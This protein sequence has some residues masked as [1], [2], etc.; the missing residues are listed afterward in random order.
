MRKG[1]EVR[2][3]SGCGA[4]LRWM[5][6]VLSLCFSDEERLGCGRC[7]ERSG[8]VGVF[9]SLALITR[10][11]L[12]AVVRSFFCASFSSAGGAG[13]ATFSCTTEV[14]VRCPKPAPAH[15]KE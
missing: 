5:R 2:N 7:V 3:R 4:F 6:V 15:T 11:A 12:K 1:G 13:A 8:V 14:V 10:A 9:S